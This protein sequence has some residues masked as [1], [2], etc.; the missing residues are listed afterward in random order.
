ML[1]SLPAQPPLSHVKDMSCLP[2]PFATLS[3][4]IWHKTQQP[5]PY[6]DAVFLMESYVRAMSHDK[7]IP[8]LLWLLEHPPLYTQGMSS[9]EGDGPSQTGMLPLYKSGRGGGYTYHGPGQRI[10][11]AMMSLSHAHHPTLTIA[12]YIQW[13]HD[14]CG[15]SLAHLGIIAVRRGQQ[16]GLWVSVG[17]VYKKIA[18]FG[19]RMRHGMS[20]H[21]VSINAHCALE[22]FR[23]IRPCGYDGQDITSLSALGRPSSLRHVDDALLEDLR[24]SYDALSRKGQHPC[25]IIQQTSQACPTLSSILSRA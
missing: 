21:G 5:V 20:F 15:C 6:S 2:L 4:I 10:L 19:I 23:H 1:C 14:W 7:T 24:A 9:L 22:P 16:S 8:P 3:A 11:Y 18:F 17:G 13:L 25:H 12:H